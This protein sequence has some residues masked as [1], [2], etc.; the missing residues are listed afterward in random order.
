M[1][2]H[3]D[4]TVL[5]NQAIQTDKEVTAYKS[6]IIIK[7]KKEK[8][9]VP[10]DVAIP[11]D[12]KSHAKES[13]K[14]KIQDFMCSDTMNV[15]HEMYDYGGNKWSHQNGTKRFKEKYGSHTMKTFSRFTTK[16]S[17]TP[18]IAHNAESTAVLVQEEYQEEKAVTIDNTNKKQQYNNNNRPHLSEQFCT[19][20][21]NQHFYW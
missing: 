1:Y 2:E 21:A 9:S 4:D 6:D 17:Y 14:T 10:I 19:P 13:R 8:T 20:S 15:E 7:N 18:N 16:D 12:K 11:A 3:E 5:W